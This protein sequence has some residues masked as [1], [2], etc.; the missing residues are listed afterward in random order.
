MKQGIAEYNGENSKRKMESQ[1]SYMQSWKGLLRKQTAIRALTSAGGSLLCK[2]G[3]L[4][5]SQMLFIQSKRFR[6]FFF[7]FFKVRGILWLDMGNI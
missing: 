6:S 7:H 3:V 5:Q 2:L 4:R 1:P